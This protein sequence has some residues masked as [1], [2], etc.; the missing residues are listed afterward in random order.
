M[1]LLGHSYGAFLS[2]ALAG[3]FP[4]L[5]IKVILVGSAVFDDQCAAMIQHAR[6]ARMSDAQKREAAFLEGQLTR[7]RGK[8][9]DA[10]LL[11]LANLDRVV[12]GY[13]PLPLENPFLHV[14]YEIYDKV[15]RDVRTRRQSGALLAYG[16]KIQCPVVALHGTYDPHPVEG[17]VK[18]LACVLRNF[19]F[20]AMERC[21]HYPA[22][23]RRARD[24]FF[25]RLKSELV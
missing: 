9:K 18:P 7:A 21:G 24:T 1:V 19:R 6:L 20:I 23:E 3:L 17:V 8:E 16:K 15:W 13:D 14:S 5:V 25:K 2:Y 12:D 11:Q 10:V 4:H 22:C